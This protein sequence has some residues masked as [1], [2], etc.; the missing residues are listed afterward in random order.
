MGALLGVAQGSH[1]PPRFIVMRY[2]AR[3]ARPA[4]GLLGK[5]ITFDTG[6]ISIKPA[7]GMEEM[8]TD[9]S[10]A[11][12]V[13]SAMIAIGKLKPGRNVV[14]LVPATENA[15]GGG[16]QRPGDVVRA[17]DG[18]SIEVVN[19][20]A[21]GRLVLAD[22]IGYAHEI[23][24]TP[25]I[26]LATLTGAIKIALGLLRTGL[27]TN[28]EA[29]MQKVLEAAEKT[30]ERMWH[31]PLDDEYFDDVKSD[32]ADVKNTGGR[33]GGSIAGA[34]LLKL[35]AGKTPW[36]HLDI[37]GTARSERQHGYISKGGTGVGVRTLVRFVE[38]FSER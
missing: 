21:E 25:L 4:I 6:G 24:L 3:D 33:W 29:T 30:G 18:K 38:L 28:D 10:G 19:T 15:V 16:A 36:V 32:V 22:A 8:K 31:M 1:E 2:D 26:D 23:G 12:A 17:M 34:H 13:I 27:F 9:M 5:G 14:G 20:D 7:A 37:A 35:F 11:A